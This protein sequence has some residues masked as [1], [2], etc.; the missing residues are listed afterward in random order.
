MARHLDAG[1]RARHKAAQDVPAS[2][3]DGSRNAGDAEHEKSPVAAATATGAE[4]EIDAENI[5]DSR[6]E[7]QGNSPRLSPDGP[8]ASNAEILWRA[9]LTP[10]PLTGDEDGKPPDVRGFTQWKYPPGIETLRRWS[11]RWPGAN[12]GIVTGNK[13][14]V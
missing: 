11:E 2:S 12:I 7:G 6:T 9:G 5:A 13:V 14:V 10:I 1:P 3:V 8:F 4:A